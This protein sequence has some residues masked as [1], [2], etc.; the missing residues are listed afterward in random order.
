MLLLGHLDIE[1]LLG[2]ARHAAHAYGVV[3]VLVVVKAHARA[4]VEATAI[5]TKGL[6][7]PA[8]DQVV[9][10]C[11][12]VMVAELLEKLGAELGG[13]H[14]ERI[15]FQALVLL[16]SLDRIDLFAQRCSTSEKCAAHCQLRLIVPGWWHP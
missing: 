6:G 13:A 10:R 1:S 3:A 9:D 7:E 15:A 2:T 16:G 4:V 12:V 5:S 14:G 11:R 8:V